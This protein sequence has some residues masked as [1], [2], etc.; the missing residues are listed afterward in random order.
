MTLTWYRILYN[1]EIPK[2]NTD[3]KKNPKF[4]NLV[5]TCFPLYKRPPHP[6]VQPNQSTPLSQETLN[7]FKL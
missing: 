5:K 3:E 7:G 1:T 2:K 4:F 6:K